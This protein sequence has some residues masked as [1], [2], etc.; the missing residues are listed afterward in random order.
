MKNY[1]K[2]LEIES[3]AALSEIK[4]AY[5]KLA[6]KYHPD[7]N[8]EPNASMIF[9]E[10]TEA[11]EVLTDGERKKIYDKLYSD[12]FVNK[13]QSAEFTHSE[14]QQSWTDIGRKKAAEYSKMTFDSFTTKLLDYFLFNS[15]NRRNAVDLNIGDNISMCMENYN[16]KH[17]LKNVDYYCYDN[18]AYNLT[19]GF[20]NDVKIKMVTLGVRNNI[21][22]QKRIDIKPP[23]GKKDFLL[24]LKGEIESLFHVN[25]KNLDE[26]KDLTYGANLGSIGIG[27][28]FQDYGLL[29]WKNS[30]SINIS[31]TK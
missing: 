24:K 13:N 5:R 31:T 7:K 27:I 10:I 20:F 23:S 14:A 1:Y 18:F 6:F 22:I 29:F 3:S 25:F 28:Q 2:L 4:Q 19:G 26:V 12:Y 11:Y 15:E 17:T 21:V 9:I 16:F 8:H 30:L